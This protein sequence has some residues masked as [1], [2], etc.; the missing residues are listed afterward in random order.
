MKLKRI[1]LLVWIAAAFLGGCVFETA[2]KDMKELAKT[3]KTAGKQS[4]TSIKQDFAFFFRYFF[5]TQSTQR[6]IA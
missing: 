1:C 2:K 6:K 4:L 3:F 5:L